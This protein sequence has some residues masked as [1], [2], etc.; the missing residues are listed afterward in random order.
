[1]K[2]VMPGLAQ[3]WQR[4]YDIG[5]KQKSKTQID[6]TAYEVGYQL[7]ISLEC[8][9]RIPK[10]DPVR[11]LSAIMDRIDYRRVKMAYSRLG[12]NEYPARLLAKVWI[13]GYMRQMIHT[14]AVEAACREN[15]K[16]MYLLEGHKAPDHNTLARFRSRVL[17]SEAGEDL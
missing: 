11:L 10:D 3:T 5:V 6:Y 8:D 17:R 13:Y 16:F 15:L 9:I 2:K 14:R 4:L 12:R 7:R 1:M